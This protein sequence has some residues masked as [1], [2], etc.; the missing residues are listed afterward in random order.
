MVR[1]EER[2]SVIGAYHVFIG[3]VFA[4]FVFFA[5]GEF[6]GVREVAKECFIHVVI[7]GIF[8]L[9]ARFILAYYADSKSESKTNSSAPSSKDT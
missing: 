1:N 2:H 8:F 7:I 4:G 3:E 5:S 9:N 6:G